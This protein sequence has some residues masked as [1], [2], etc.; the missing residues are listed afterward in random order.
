[1]APTIEAL[2]EKVTMAVALTYEVPIAGNFAI[3]KSAI[4][5]VMVERRRAAA[6][7]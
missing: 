5:K 2:W 4:M 7:Q 6:Y 1:M 3:P